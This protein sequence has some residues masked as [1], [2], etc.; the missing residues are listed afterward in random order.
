M[1]ESFWGRCASPH[2][3]MSA[4][5]TVTLVLGE[6]AQPHRHEA[7]GVSQHQH[8]DPLQSGGCPALLLTHQSQSERGLWA[9]LP[10][11]GSPA[12]HCF[13]GTSVAPYC[14]PQSGLTQPPITYFP[15]G[16]GSSF[17]A[18]PTFLSPGHLLFL[19]SL[20]LQGCSQLL[21]TFP[22][23]RKAAGYSSKWSDPSQ[24]AGQA[25]P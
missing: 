15:S 7:L 21:V 6:M 1:L 17:W 13:P 12:P 2:A 19:L 18:P 10:P 25:L 5:A 23:A 22:Q 11:W 9:H 8:A 4:H 16:W 14:P 24:V 20:Y 3:C